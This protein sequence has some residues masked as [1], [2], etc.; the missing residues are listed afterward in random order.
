MTVPAVRMSTVVVNTTDVDRLIP[1]W[2]GLLQVG[3]AQR[4][5]DMFV[6]LDRQQGAGVGLAFQRVP[7]PTPGRRRLHLDLEVE[8]LDAAQR[9]IE[10][11]GGSCLERHEM[12]GFHWRVMTDPDG[13]EFCIAGSPG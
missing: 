6:W 2:R 13:N 9:R 10:D 11:L 5:D 12:A 8:D 3:V 7:D 1:F 4:I